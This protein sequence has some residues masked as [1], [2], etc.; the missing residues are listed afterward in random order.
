MLHKGAKL[1]T[2][3]RHHAARAAHGQ[4]EVKPFER[5]PQTSAPLDDGAGPYSLD[6]GL[7]LL[8]ALFASYYHM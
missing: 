4:R 2:R 3:L 7:R 8:N 6:D 1:P 5:L